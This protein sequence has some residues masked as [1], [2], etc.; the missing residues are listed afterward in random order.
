MRKR[1]E[2][3]ADAR[4]RSDVDMTKQVKAGTLWF[5]TVVLTMTLVAAGCS[6]TKDKDSP[7]SGPTSAAREPTREESPAGRGAAAE[8]GSAGGTSTPEG[9]TSISDNPA[10]FTVE[11]ITP[12]SDNTRNLD[13]LFRPVLNDLFEGVK[14]VAET[15]RETDNPLRKEVLGTMTYVVRRLLASADADELHAKLLAAGFHA[16]PRY[17]ARPVHGRAFVLMSLSKSTSMGSYS[18]GIRLDLS[19]QTIQVESFELG[20][21]YD[22]L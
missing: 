11:E 17:G 9:M 7:G 13:R 8:T 4:S 10:F 1:M 3:R 5:W 15:G 14:L 22:R 12:A 18:L 20:S 19:Q 6:D 21:R 2:T 16:T